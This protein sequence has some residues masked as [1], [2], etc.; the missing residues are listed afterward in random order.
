MKYQEE[1]AP[2]NESRSFAGVFFLILV[3]S[4]GPETAL[5][6]GCPVQAVGFSNCGVLGLGVG[7]GVPQPVLIGNF[8]H[9]AGGGALTLT[10]KDDGTVWAWGLNSYGQLGDGTT[11]RRLTPVQVSGLTGVTAISPRGAH[12]L[13]LKSDGTVWAWE[14]MPAANWGTERQRIA[15]PRS[16]SRS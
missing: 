2:R 10:I 11:T 9:V 8:V 16:R 6:Q 7:R 3:L 5:A 15:G 4:A 14:P 12:S 13:A 1:H